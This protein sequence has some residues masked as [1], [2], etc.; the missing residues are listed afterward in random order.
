M[1]IEEMTFQFEHTYQ[2]DKE[3]TEEM[4]VRVKYQEFDNSFVLQNTNH[5]GWKIVDI[6]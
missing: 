3:S 2:S 6:D 1:F 4:V 5:A